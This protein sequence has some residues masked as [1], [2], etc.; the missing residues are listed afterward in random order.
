MKITDKYILSKFF[1]ILAFSLLAFIIV[2]L[3]VDIIENIDKFIDNKAP[4]YLIAQYYILYLPFITVL[5]IPVAVLLAT[6]FTIGGPSRYN[7]LTIM[8]SQRYV[9]VSAFRSPSDKRVYH[10]LDNNH[11]LGFCDGAR[12]S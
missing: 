3:I 2:V 11:F 4:V 9:V 10:I 12:G 6:M 5:V 1:Y 8:K 7:E